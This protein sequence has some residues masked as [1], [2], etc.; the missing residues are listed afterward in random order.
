M[1]FGC[2]E[3]LKIKFQN[4]HYTDQRQNENLALKK[5]VKGLKRNFFFFLNPI[6]FK[7]RAFGCQEKF[8]NQI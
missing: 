3:N 5:I 6:Y 1:C 2:Q 4:T 7:Y 8:A